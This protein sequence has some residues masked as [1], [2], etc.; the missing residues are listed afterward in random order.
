VEVLLKV[1]GLG[2]IQ[3]AFK[4]PE[5][6]SASQGISMLRFVLLTDLLS[7]PQS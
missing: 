5:P 4:D 6:I 1:K 7:N 2:E 3:E